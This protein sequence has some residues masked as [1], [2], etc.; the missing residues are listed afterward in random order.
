M[1][2]YFRISEVNEVAQ[3]LILNALR[4][5]E[6]SH[7][8]TDT[9]CKCEKDYKGPTCAGRMFSVFLFYKHS[10]FCLIISP[11]LLYLGLPWLTGA[12]GF[13]NPGGDN[14]YRGISS[15]TGPYGLELAKCQWGSIRLPGSA[16]TRSLLVPTKGLPGM[17][18]RDT[19][20]D[21]LAVEQIYY[22]RGTTQAPSAW[23]LLGT[24]QTKQGVKQIQA[25]TQK[26]IQAQGNKVPGTP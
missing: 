14:S 9:Y 5:K 3:I 19:Q 1:Y 16:A 17:K 13:F 11:T 15:C 25:Q 2:S 18:S 24:E 10:C 4:F 26:Y 21:T 12:L 23:Y 22:Q 20:E 8:G 6:C 7:D